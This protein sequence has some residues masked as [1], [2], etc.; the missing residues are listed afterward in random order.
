M[1][2]VVVTHGQH[3]KAGN[4]AQDYDGPLLEQ[5]RERLAALKVPPTEA[6]FC[7]T[8][9]RHRE[10]AETLGLSDVAFTRVCGWDK[11]MFGML[12]GDRAPV[13]AFRQWIEELKRQGIRSALIVTSRGYALMVRYFLDGGERRF[14]P[15]GYFCR[16]IEAAARWPHT[17][18][19]LMETGAL[20]TFEV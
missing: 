8:M 2:L 17:Q 13:D 5:S 4:T 6:V 16:A 18:I 14:G 11:D 15:F 9:R 1:R 12:D 20:H 7:G 3:K 19:A 10:T